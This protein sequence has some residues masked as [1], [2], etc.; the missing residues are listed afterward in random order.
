MATGMQATDTATSPNKL[1][2]ALSVIRLTQIA[3]VRDEY[4]AGRSAIAMPIFS[5][6]GRVAAAVELTV[7]EPTPTSRPQG[8]LTVACRS[9]SRQLATELH[10]GA[11]VRC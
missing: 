11:T 3:T 4:Q 1:R 2:H 10:N 9:L 6:G 7:F 8:A 5:G